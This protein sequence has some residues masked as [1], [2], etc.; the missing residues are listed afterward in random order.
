VLFSLAHYVGPL[1]DTLDLHSFTF[2]FL[3]GVFFALLF[4]ARGF[5]IA[6]GSHAAYDILVGLRA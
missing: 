4:E 6:A 3:A 1:G 2:R 5:G